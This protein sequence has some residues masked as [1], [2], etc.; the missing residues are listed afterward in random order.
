FFVVMAR[1]KEAA[2]LAV[3]EARKQRFRELCRP[4]EILAP[5]PRLQ[6]LDQRSQQKCMV[7][8][9]RIE[10][11]SVAAAG[12][13]QTAVTPCGALERIGGGKRQFRPARLPER[14]CG[15]GEPRD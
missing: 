4:F 14:A 5:E 13:Q 7:I 10:I 15:T 1:E 3:L 8:E 12:R 2:T 6:Q 11:G 9:I